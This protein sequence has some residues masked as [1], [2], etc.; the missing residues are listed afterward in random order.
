MQVVEE[1]LPVYGLMDMFRPE[2]IRITLVLFICW[3][4]ITLLYYGQDL[5][6]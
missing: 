6:S 3:P 4:V 2:Q 5:L 1:D